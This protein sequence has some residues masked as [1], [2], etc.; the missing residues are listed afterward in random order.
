MREQQK[1]GRNGLS[2]ETVEVGSMTKDLALLV[3]A[4]RKWPSATG[5]LDEIDET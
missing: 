3:G 2:V 4:N 5:V 1:S